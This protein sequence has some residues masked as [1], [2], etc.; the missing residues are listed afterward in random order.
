MKEV[1]YQ[2]MDYDQPN[3]CMAC[4]V[5]LEELGQTETKERPARC[6]NPE[7]QREVILVDDD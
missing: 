2:I 6:L 7:C 5:R 3:C 1:I 4:G